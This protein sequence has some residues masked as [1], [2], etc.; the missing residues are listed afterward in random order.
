VGTRA[1]AGLDDHQGV[2]ARAQIEPCGMLGGFFGCGQV[3]GGSQS[4]EANG[5]LRLRWTHSA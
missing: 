2:H 5:D 4:H 1:R 3:V